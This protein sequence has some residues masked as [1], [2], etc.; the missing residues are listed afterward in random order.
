MHSLSRNVQVVPLELMV[1]SGFCDYPMTKKRK[2]GRKKIAA[3]T[4]SGGEDHWNMQGDVATFYFTVALV[5][6]H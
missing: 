1:K 4:H 2:K 3:V 5:S 6:K